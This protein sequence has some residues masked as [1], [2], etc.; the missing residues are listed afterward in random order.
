MGWSEPNLTTKVTDFQMWDKILQ[1]D[2]LIKVGLF[3]TLTVWH[4][5]LDQIREILQDRILT[6]DRVV[7][8][9]LTQLDDVMCVKYYYEY[10]NSMNIYV[11]E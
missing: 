8:I 2:L 6:L 7:I 1:D 10:L 3:E 9:Y 4:E 11:E 5:F